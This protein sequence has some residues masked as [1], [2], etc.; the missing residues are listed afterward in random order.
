LI[1]AFSASKYSA[2]VGGG[3]LGTGGAYSISPHD[4]HLTPPSLVGIASLY[5]F[6]RP[7]M[8]HR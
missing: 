7:G 5:N 2:N 6:A 4:L 3:S 8:R 1:A